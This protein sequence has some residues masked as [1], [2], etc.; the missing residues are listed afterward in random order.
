MG[1]GGVPRRGVLT[2]FP[3]GSTLLE[4]TSAGVAVLCRDEM[5]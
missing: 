2:A 3:V 5:V 4:D 1:M